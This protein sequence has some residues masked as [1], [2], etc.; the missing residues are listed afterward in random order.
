VRGWERRQPSTTLR[1]PV[2]SHNDDTAADEHAE[3]SGQPSVI[4][5]SVLRVE[6]NVA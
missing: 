3:N 5:G 1:H 4:K 6:D 2:Y